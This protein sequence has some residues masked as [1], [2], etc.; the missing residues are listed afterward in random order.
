MKNY[1]FIMVSVTELVVTILVFLA[2]GRWADNHFQSGSLYIAI[3]A[4]LGSG[5]GFARL[6]MR[7]QSIKDDS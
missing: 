3:G 6:I 1:G 7:L 2:A 4:V 5:I